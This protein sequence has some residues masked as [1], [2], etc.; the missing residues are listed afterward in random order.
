MDHT[1]EYQTVKHL[2]ENLEEIHSE[3]LLPK[4]FLDVTPK[5]LPMKEQIDEL[6]FIKTE[7]FCS[8]KV[9]IKK[10]HRLGE[11]ICQTCIW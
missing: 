7:N 1:T 11:I 8:S 10:S 2:K 4:D 3:L 9:T 6:A 5:A